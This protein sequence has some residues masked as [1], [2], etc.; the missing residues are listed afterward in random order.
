L[1]GHEG[2]D[3]PEPTHDWAFEV[4]EDVSDEIKALKQQREELEKA[5]SKS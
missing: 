4:I 3:I 2:F 5:Q 1:K